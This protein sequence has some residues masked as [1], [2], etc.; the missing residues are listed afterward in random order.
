MMQGPR[1]SSFGAP[2]NRGPPTFEVTRRAFVRGMTGLSV[3]LTCSAVLGGCEIINGPSHRRVRRVGDLF[4]DAADSSHVYAEIVR[5]LDKLGWV[6]DR[7]SCSS[8]G[9]PKGAQRIIR[10]SQR[11]WWV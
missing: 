3:A 6:E 10:S 8:G 9:S 4:T 5:A 7:T 1:G 2:G 11:R